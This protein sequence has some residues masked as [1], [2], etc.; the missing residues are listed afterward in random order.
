MSHIRHVSDPP[1]SVPHLSSLEGGFL[2]N[3]KVT[4]LTPMGCRR[5]MSWKVSATRKACRD[6]LSTRVY[7]RGRPTPSKVTGRYQNPRSC[8]CLGV[9]R[10]F[11]DSPM[12]D[13]LGSS[14]SVGPVK[15]VG[16]TLKFVV[17]YFRD[18]VSTLLPPDLKSFTTVTTWVTTFGVGRIK[19]L[20]G[21][22]L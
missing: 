3:G 22:P 6:Q 1:S 16:W 21:E 10:Y 2:L 17:P 11:H 20:G 19:V 7:R 14:C 8:L 9:R 5:S 13:F 4:L 12:T 18:K 15:L